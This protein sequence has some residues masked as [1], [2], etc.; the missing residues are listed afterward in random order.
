MSVTEGA[1][2]VYIPIITL[3]R[4]SG[5][6]ENW[7]RTSR[8]CITVIRRD[9]LKAISWLQHGL[10]GI[11]FLNV[12]TLKFGFLLDG[13]FDFIKDKIPPPYLVP[14]SLC[15]LY[16]STTERLSLNVESNLKRLSL[17]VQSNFVSA[18]NKR[19][20][21]FSVNS[22]LISSNLYLRLLIFVY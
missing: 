20:T 8:S 18:I 2:F 1:W 17:N 5:T 21:I 13:M 11:C 10:Q 7:R 9:N 22:S 16:P 19:S 12:Q 15:N 6:S 14:S 3:V 4:L